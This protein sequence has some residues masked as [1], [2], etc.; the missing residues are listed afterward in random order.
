MI[1]LRIG[2]SES[3]ILG[4]DQKK[5]NQLKELISYDIDQSPGKYQKYY[6]R[7]RSLLSKSG[8]YP[9]GLNY[10]VLNWLKIN[11]L[12][13]KAHDQRVTA[14]ILQKPF[15][16]NLQGVTPYAAQ[17][18]AVKQSLSVME[19]RGTIRMPTGSGKSVTMALLVGSLGV[20]TLIVVPNLV[21]R[22]QLTESFKAWFGY[23]RVGRLKEGKD[24][25]IDNI[26]GLTSRE[27]K[28]YGCLILDEAHHAASK[29]YRTLNRKSWK[30]IY[31]RFS[32]TATPFRSKAEE[33]LLL[34]SV[35][36]ETIYS[37]SHAESVKQGHILPIE[38]YYISI[39]RTVMKGNTK[40]W[41]SVYS[42]LVVNNEIRNEYIQKILLK[43]HTNK[44]STLC[45]VK[46]IKHGEI[47]SSGAFPFVSAQNDER[48]LIE[49]FSKGEIPILI[50][51]TGV[52]G[53]GTDTRACEFV[54]I[55]GSGKAKVQFMQQVG[56][57]LRRFDGKT[58]AKI[59]LLYDKSHRFLLRHFK[60]QCII[61]KEE[62]QVEPVE[63]LLEDF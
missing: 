52:V 10:L 4:L 49:Q 22:E 26:D 40:A 9:S 32:F 6:S 41:A 44:V 57:A 31:Y 7:R 35:T 3:R 17:L 19:G 5:Y 37:L 15:V 38:A 2:N 36:G 51:T 11:A 16:L 24:I 25:A 14:K 13:F 39:P 23:D 12:D 34:E 58:S 27:L 56:R 45:L 54:L 43:L 53:E 62:Y 50:G 59:I 60:E 42:E 29:T 55:A 48:H 61:L 1:E 8:A 18:D 28:D 46:E 20:R 21:L 30:N 47:L 63:L 33:Q